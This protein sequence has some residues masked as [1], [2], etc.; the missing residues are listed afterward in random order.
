MTPT[1]PKIGIGRRLALAFM[2]LFGSATALRAD[3]AQLDEAVLI[4]HATAHIVHKNAA[5]DVLWEGDSK[6]N[7]LIKAGIDF[8]FD[9][10]YTD[11]S[12]A[13]ASTGLSY[14]ALSNDTVSETAD[15]T[16]LSNEIAANGLSRALSTY[17]HTTGTSTCTLTKVFTCTTTSQACQKAAL[18]SAASSGAMHHVLSFT[19]RTLQVDDT[20]TITFTITLQAA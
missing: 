18:F 6:P 9:Q 3:A 15:S 4:R 14:I 11:G 8:T 13:G 16:T 19:Q 17:A 10:A 7:L 20:I 1:L 12:P 2:V 5:G